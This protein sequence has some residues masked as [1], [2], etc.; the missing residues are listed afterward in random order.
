[1]DDEVPEAPDEL[2]GGEEPN[3]PDA[4]LEIVPVP[5]AARMSGML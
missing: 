3:L 1:M 2:A 4:R 5:R